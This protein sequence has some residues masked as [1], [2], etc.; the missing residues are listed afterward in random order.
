MQYR[1]LEKTEIWIT[2]ISLRDAD[3]AA[4]AEAAGKVLGLTP[5]EI[6]VTDAQTNHLVFDVL[7]PTVEAGQIVARK[8]A[9]LDALGRVA[10]VQISPDTE[11]HSDGILGMI[12]LG[13]DEGREVLERTEKLADQIKQRLARRAKI[14]PTGTE[15]IN[16]QIK[17][18]NTPF[19][20]GR[21]E[22]MGFSVTTSPPLP[23]QQNRIAGSLRDAVEEGYG[24]I[25]T[26]GGVGA[27]GKDQTVEALLALDPQAAT[28]YVLKFTKGQGRHAKDGVRLG[29]GRLGQ[30]T[31]V[32]L[33]GPNDEVRLTWPVL[34]RGLSENWSKER[35]ASHL[36]DALRQK[37]LDRQPHHAH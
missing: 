15:V 3:L 13:P 9:L 37:F 34:S 4:C 1:L 24:L 21:L 25:V 7:T 29:V 27:E 18:T 16:G 8:Q 12:S 2:P 33:P 11:V 30:S 23:D 6:M 19:L 36:A 26:T 28:P 20:K 14:F 31:M 22:D 32:T 35:L 5:P 17:D 10:G